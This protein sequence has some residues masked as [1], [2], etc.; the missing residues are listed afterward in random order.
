MRRFLLRNQRQL[1]LCRRLPNVGTTFID[2]EISGGII[3]PCRI[4]IGLILQSVIAFLN[5]SVSIT[6]RR[7]CKKDELTP[8]KVE[9]LL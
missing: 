7:V 5:V 6:F 4:E 8:I 1:T 3:L 2:V 9:K